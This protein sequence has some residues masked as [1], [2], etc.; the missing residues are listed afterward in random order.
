MKL[1]LKKS[2]VIVSFSLV[3]LTFFMAFRHIPSQKGS[4]DISMQKAGSTTAIM[5]VVVIGSGPAGFSAALYAARQGIKTLVI[6][7]NNPGGALVGTSYVENW[8]GRPKV[9]GPTVIEDLKGQAESFGAQV[10]VGDGVVGVDFKKWPYE[11]KTEAG[12]IIN[13]LSVVIAT[14]STPR[15]LNIPGEREYWGKGVTTCA[16]CD[17]PYHKGKDVVVVGGGD[18]A[19]EEAIQL[20]QAG[21]KTI[22]IAVRKDSLRASQAMQDKVKNYS[23]IVIEYNTEV[24]KI[25]GDEL[26]VNAVELFNN[27]T[28]KS[29]IKSVSGFFLAIGHLPN[30]Q[31]FQ[32]QL[33]LDENSYVKLMGRTQ[34]T[35]VPGVFAAG[36]VD[37]YRYRQAG[38]AAGEGIAA[39]LDAAAFLQMHGFNPAIASQMANN[40][41]SPNAIER[42]PVTLVNNL[43]ELSTKFKEANG[44]I[45]LDFYAPY[46]P[47]CMQMLPVLEEVAAK[48]KD[49]TFLKIDTSKTS[50]VSKQ[51]SVGAIPCLLAFKDSQLI[52]RYN[53]SM[54]RLQLEEFIA[55]INQSPDAVV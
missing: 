39:G 4:I 55:K 15:V 44:I 46:C 2:L 24:K 48:Y 27:K 16:I 20:A 54:N 18:S 40:F 51:Y 1:T 17:A 12:R 14:G 6:P 45:L 42:I 36:D 41:F 26:A 34:E 47:S 5:P 32:G 30:T 52:G 19:L 8:P 49:I 25:M 23:N 38:Y 31:L 35:S 9:L 37:D 13:A 10:L 29:T 43:G 3:C 11:I 21:V 53:Q 33:E 50:D 7:G 28:G 22:T